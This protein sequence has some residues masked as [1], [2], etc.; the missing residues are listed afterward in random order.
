MPA[1]ATE[2]RLLIVSHHVRRHSV[3]DIVLRGLLLHLDRTRFEVLV[4]HLGNVE[5]EETR[6]ARGQ[7][8]GWRDRPVATQNDVG[9]DA[10]SRGLSDAN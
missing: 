7:V 8:D 3:W 6:F 5:D 1:I 9:P 10:Q 4:Y 2:P